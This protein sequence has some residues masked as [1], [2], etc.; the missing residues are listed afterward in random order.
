[1]LFEIAEIFDSVRIFAVNVFRVL[2]RLVT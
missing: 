2:R 1:V